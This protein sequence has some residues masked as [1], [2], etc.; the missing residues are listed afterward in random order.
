MTRTKKESPGQMAWIAPIQGS[1]VVLPALGL[2]CLIRMISTPKMASCG[3]ARF[4]RLL[5]KLTF[6]QKSINGRDKEAI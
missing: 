2:I 5:Y 4:I 6:A 1:R 3:R